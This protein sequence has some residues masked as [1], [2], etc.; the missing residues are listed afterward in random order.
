VAHEVV[1]VST[2]LEAVIEA[3][4]VR[5]MAAL[6]EPKNIERLSRCDEAAKAEIAR[7][8]EKLK[9]QGRVGMGLDVPDPAARKFMQEMEHDPEFQRI[10]RPAVDAFHGRGAVRFVV[11]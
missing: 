11:A 2:T 8:I 5:G 6:K 9:S 7:R 10:W 4:R 1:V 3:V